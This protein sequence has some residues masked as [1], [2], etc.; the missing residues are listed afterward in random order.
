MPQK[1]ILIFIDWF[2]P[3]Y[4]AGGPIS[5]NANLIAHL[6]LEYKF[7]VITRNTDYC[8]TKPYEN[9]APLAWI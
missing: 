7:F 6:G 5:S 3:G 8:E 1:N 2:L 9:I 4:K